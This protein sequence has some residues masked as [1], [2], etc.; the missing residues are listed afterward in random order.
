M[1][2][3]EKEV[4]R[5][6]TIFKTLP[7]RHVKIISHLDADGLASA[8]ILVATFKRAHIKFTLSVIKQI[9]ESL[10]KEL[11][12]EQINNILLT[13]IGS[14]SLSLL[15]LQNKEIFILDHHKPENFQ[16][17]NVNHLNPH[18]LSIDGSKE[19]SGAGVTYLFAKEFDKRNTD[20]AHLAIIGAIGDMQESNGFFGLNK[21]VLQD[22][23]D[24]KKIKVIK[25]LRLFGASTKPLYKLLE[26]SDFN[27]PGV[28]RSKRGS[29][30]F[31]ETLGIE[32]KEGSRW[33]TLSDL[34]EIELQK[35]IT[36]LIIKRLNEDKPGE[37]LGDTYNLDGPISDAKEF[38]TILNSCGRL[39][40][41]AVGIALCLGDKEAL[42]EAHS[43]LNMYK[44][45]IVNAWTWFN[46]N[47]NTENVIEHD[48]YILINARDNIKDTIIGTF[49]SMLTKSLTRD[50]MI[51]AM[52]RN[53]E[54]TKISVRA[55]KPTI[56]L[57]NFLMATTPQGAISGGHS[58]AAGALI[59]TKK[60]DEFITNITNFFSQHKINQLAVASENSKKQDL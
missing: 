7:D 15:N 38:S 4:N 5:V 30:N 41:P 59:P 18:T 37:I 48:D 33:R 34:N 54:K 35:L 58:E 2:S 1:I 27:I 6:C 21:M 40:K 29:L 20:L 32:L 39:A 52:A 19:I 31:L 8:A 28:S 43:V 25:G 46:S 17:T 11:E 44:K 47:K 55:T 26:Y 10:I 51:I 36:E 57:Q 42:T 23:I 53:A 50:S 13:D 45:E 22:A 9:D 3:F 14:G 24:S 12:K 60:E 16:N 49:A 56:D